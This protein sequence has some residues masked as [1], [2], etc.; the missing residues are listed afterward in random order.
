MSTF[1]ERQRRDGDIRHGTTAGATRHSNLG[2]PPCD[3]CRA[4]KSA[5][6]KEWRSVSGAVQRG[7]IHAK[8]QRLALKKLKD[9]HLAEYRSYYIHFRDQLFAEETD[10]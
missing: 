5:Y 4:A 8:A 9:A 7:R 3:A 6:D 1:R 10:D 2:E